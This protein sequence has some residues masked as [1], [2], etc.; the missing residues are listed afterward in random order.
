MAQVTNNGNITPIGLP[1]GVLVPPQQTVEVR[2]WDKIKSHPIVAHYLTVG[3]LS[4]EGELEDDAG[5]AAEERQAL[6]AQ[7]KALGVNAGSN[8]KPETLKAKLAE[9]LVAAKDDAIAKLK[10]KGIEV[11]DDVTLEE[12]QAELAKQQ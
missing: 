2:G 6:L 4:A 10:E 9:A 12:L 5:D 8:S 11:G 1:N 7:L 3:V